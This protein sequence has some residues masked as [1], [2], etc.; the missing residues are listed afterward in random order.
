MLQKVLPAWLRGSLAI[1]LHALLILIFSIPVYVFGVAK[2]IV[3][4]KKW[5]D[6]WTKVI[7]DIPIVWMDC[8]MLVMKLFSR[9][10]VV[11]Q[12]NVKLSKDNWYL[13]LSNHQSWTDILVLE[14]VLRHRVP[15]IKF[16]MKMQLIW[17]PFLG[18]ACW[19]VGNPFMKRYSA[20][21]IAKNPALKGKD[22]E[23]TRKMCTHFKTEPLT[24]VNFPEGTRFTKE[25]AARQ[26]SP[27]KHL[28]KPRAGGLAFTLMT[29]GEY[30]R[31]IINVT[32]CYP[33]K[34]HSFWDYVCGR[35]N[36]VIIKIETMPITPDLLGNYLDDLKFKEYFQE[37]INNFWHE[38]DLQLQQMVQG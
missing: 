30:L 25:K 36:K 17:V 19:I 5:R 1:T 32:I 12:S 34:N 31:E 18:L 8:N 23:T 33:E 11:V 26:E 4:A 7:N 24:L 10:K 22:L 2:F 16:F 13:L 38:K 6:F 35:I 27:Y 21:Q 28:L 3:P 15:V 14:R 29:M 20:A 37:W 9:M